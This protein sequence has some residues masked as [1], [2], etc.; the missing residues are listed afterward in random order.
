VR[1]SDAHGQRRVTPPSSP[2]RPPPASPGTLGGSNFWA[3]LWASLLDLA[4]FGALLILA[5]DAIA[6]P[7]DLPWKPF[8]LDRPWGLSSRV[9]LELAAG[10]PAACRAA[11]RQA[12]VAFTEEPRRRDGRCET[13]DTV[14]LR[15]GVAR[16]QPAAPVM[17][18]PL[19]LAY[20]AW[21]RQ[22]LRPAGVVR[23][24]HYGTYA[25]RNVYGRAS[26]RRSE[27]ALANALDVAGVRLSDGRR[28]T[29]ARDFRDDGPDG[30]KVRLLRDVACE[31]FRATLSPDY[32]AAHDDHLH[33]DWGF[34]SICR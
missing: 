31:V 28:L 23:V 5:V 16:L 1:P 11:L 15:S 18:C 3:A 13:T 33:L 20:A 25:C 7:Q 17:T 22:A 8:R 32:N 4:L 14:R 12:N 27:H 34:H 10:D 26:G 30:V 6:P 21:D 2:S 19:A 29:V 24:D 9:Q